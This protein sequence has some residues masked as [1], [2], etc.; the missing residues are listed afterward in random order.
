MLKSVVVTGGAGFIGSAACRHLLARGTHV[1]CLDAMTYAASEDTVR[2][3]ERRPNFTMVRKDIRDE[4]SLSGIFAEAEIDAILAF[5]AE[6]HVD[7][8]IAA[9]GDFLTTNV[10][11]T[12]QLLQQARRYHSDLPAERKERF[13]FLHVSTDEVYGDLEFDEPAF[14]ENT[15]YN[16]SSPYSASKAASDHLVKA[17]GRTF[18]LPILLT[19]CSNNYGPYQFPEKLI[20]TIIARALE[21]E[22]LPVYGDGR[23]IRDWLHV[24][25]HISALTAVLERGRLGESYNVG[26]RNEVANI[27]LVRQICAAL[28]QLAPRP[29]GEPHAS[30][31]RFVKDRA[32]HDLRYAIA[33]TKIET[34]LGWSPLHDF[35]EGLFSTIRWY[36]E[37]RD[38]WVPLRKATPGSR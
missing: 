10:M 24:E 34:E 16:P 29:D 13:R 20:P 32:G 33:P 12:F 18:G 7:R 21:G 1:F 37:N 17:W 5:A 35:S 22:T 19:N 23:N 25:D 38:W 15:P 4:N 14:T 9:P 27:D 31:I 30:A 2:D 11:G 28:D 8:S 36:L 3:L 6:S 26:A